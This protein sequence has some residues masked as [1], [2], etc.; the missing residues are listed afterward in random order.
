MPRKIREKGRS[1]LRRRRTGSYRKRMADKLRLYEEAFRFRKK[2]LWDQ[3]TEDMIFAVRL[4]PDLMGYVSIMGKLGD[5]FALAVYAGK[6]GFSSYLRLHNTDPEEIGEVEYRNLLVA[7]RN[8]QCS[9]E[10]KDFL[11]REEQEEIRSYAK[12]LGVRI[13]GKNAWPVFMK[14]TPGRV[15]HR[16]SD[17]KEEEYLLLALEAASWAADHS[18]SVFPELWHVEEDKGSICL[19]E[20]KDGGFSVGKT[21]LP[22][23]ELEPEYPVGTVCN[24]VSKA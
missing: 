9:Y 6:K 23:A 4:E 19:L 18:E 3:L 15:P 17:E 5:H 7:Q 21:D 20:K 22:T 12:R 13:A 8:I 1:G 14:M 16:F 24:D 2:K 11:E 10:M